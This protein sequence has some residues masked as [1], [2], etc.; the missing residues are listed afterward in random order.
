MTKNR[1]KKISDGLSGNAFRLLRRPYKLHDQLV[2]LVAFFIKAAMAAV[3][4]RHELRACDQ[5][6][7]LLRMGKR[8]NTVM[9]AMDD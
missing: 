6:I 5:L 7:R 4:E 9:N 8:H 1:Q 2:K 3:L